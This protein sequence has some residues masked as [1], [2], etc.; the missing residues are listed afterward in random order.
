MAYLY[1]S[2]NKTVDQMINFGIT[3]N[4][5]SHAWYKTI[6]RENGKP[7]LLAISIL[8]DIVYWYRPQEIRDEN[9]GH[10]LRYQKRFSGAP[11]PCLPLPE[12]L[13]YAGQNADLSEEG[14]SESYRRA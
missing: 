1:G 8:S 7:H 9:T 10:L 11:D 5:V 12:P 4:V 6:L 3:G 13:Q 2:G 14:G